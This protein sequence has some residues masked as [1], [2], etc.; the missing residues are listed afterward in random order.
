MRLVA[1]DPGTYLGIYGAS[2]TYLARKSMD[3][4][5]TQQVAGGRRQVLFP[6]PFGPLAA[7]AG[8]ATDAGY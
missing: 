1:R 5:R 2:G 3:G 7:P 8:D 6:W 4:V